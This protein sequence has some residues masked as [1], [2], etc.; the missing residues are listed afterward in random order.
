[1]KWFSYA[2]VSVLIVLGGSTHAA[3]W[4]QWRHDASRSGAT[5]EVLPGKLKQQW[6]LS[7]GRPAP[8]YA[9]NSKND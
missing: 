3:D 8:A 4:P 2:L 9:V 1:M 7:L 6:M 5:E